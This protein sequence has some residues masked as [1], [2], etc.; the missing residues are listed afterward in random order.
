MTDLALREPA[1]RGRTHTLPD[2]RREPANAARAQGVR[3]ISVVI[4]TFRRFDL[5]RRCLAA[6]CAQNIDPCSFE[7]IVCDDGNDA[8]TRALVE[9][10]A[11]QEC[12][13]GLDVRYIGVTGTRGPAGARN[14][15]WRAA[16][17]GVIAFTDDDTIP[18]PGWLAAGIHA[19]QPGVSAV[20]GR[21]D[22]P[23]GRKPTDYARDAA[24]LAR[25]EFATANCFVRREI[26]SRIGGFD[27][28]F[29]AAWREDSDLHFS[30]LRA[31]GTV[32]HDDAA[33]VVHPVRSA[34]WGCSIRQQSKAQFDALLYKKH[35]TLYH[36]RIGPGPM[37]RYYAILGSLAAA[38]AGFVVGAPVIAW[39]GGALWAGQTAWFAVQRLHDAAHTPS[40]IA[41]MIVT[42]A[43]IPPLSIFWRLC[44]AI[45][46]RVAFL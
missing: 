6:V 25:A 40:H 3:D 21:I 44:G 27:P 39:T 18:D 8:H 4:P 43:V 23:L 29:T 15:G 24:G 46:F 7:V 30:I 22:V 45:R 5:L 32:V 14:C 41:E 31:G 17:A 19:M 34:P 13:R 2:I 33:L 42:S 10:I 35:A 38:L 11:A 37:L 36:T 28:R 12:A 26:L 1:L 20:S 9:V 16:R